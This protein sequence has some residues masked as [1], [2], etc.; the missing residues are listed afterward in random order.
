MQPAATAVGVG[1]AVAWQR[2][3]GR[4]EAAAGGGSRCPRRGCFR[5]DGR[6]AA[7]RANAGDVQYLRQ[8]T[9]RSILLEESL[10]CVLPQR[11]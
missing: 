7:D 5:R 11:G 10:Q 2:T 8:K 3:V 1:G 4:Q 9:A 6:E